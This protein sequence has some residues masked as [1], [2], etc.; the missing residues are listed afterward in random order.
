MFPIHL[1]TLAFVTG[2]TSGGLSCLTIQGGILGSVLA[3]AKNKRGAMLQFLFGKLISNLILGSL[4]GAIGS[5]FLISTTT[6]AWLQILAG[7][8]MIGTALHFANIHPELRFL[9]ISTPLWLRKNISRFTK[10]H[11]TPFVAGLATAAIPCGVTQSVMVLAITTSSPLSGALVM[12]AFVLATFPQFLALGAVSGL[13]LSRISARYIVALIV[14]M[15]GIYSINTGQI[16]RGSN[17]TIQNYAYVLGITTIA[18]SQA[19]EMENGFQKIN[20]IATT[21]GYAFDHSVVKSGVPVKIVFDSKNTTGCARSFSIPSLGISK[22]LPE[23]G[24]ETVEFTPTGPGV[25]TYSCN[26]G[27][28]VGTISVL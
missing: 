6:Q 10:S 16:L 5:A 19:A 11:R 1:I 23:N 9:E 18:N 8:F 12:G 27:M 28:H 2:L 14:F 7:V 22:I 26:M 4:L 21:N 20:A 24:T 13:I 15:M 25:I 17:H 3:S